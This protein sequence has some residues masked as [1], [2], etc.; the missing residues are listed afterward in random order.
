MTRTTFQW[1]RDRS[2]RVT[3]RVRAIRRSR[4]WMDWL[5]PFRWPM[6]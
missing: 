6:D 1:V 2:A 4:G 3:R 5:L